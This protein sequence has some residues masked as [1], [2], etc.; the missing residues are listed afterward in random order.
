MKNY[1]KFA[2]V[3]LFIAGSFASNAVAQETKIPKSKVPVAV[4]TAFM[5]SYPDAKIK[6]T[7]K[8]VKGGATFYE[9]ESKDGNMKRDLLY[10]ADGGVTEME[11]I[12]PLSTAPQAVQSAITAGHA[13]AKVKSV[14][15]NT[16]GPVLTYEVAMKEKGKKA[17]EVIYNTDGTVVKP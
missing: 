7:N 13:N 14:E 15:K 17:F 9:I 3:A 5:K 10:A 2:V 1:I 12:V 4:M 16:Q 8:E 11:E 6:G